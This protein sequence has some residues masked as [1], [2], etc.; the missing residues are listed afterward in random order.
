MTKT[1]NEIV[2]AKPVN[3]ITSQYSREQVDLIKSTVAVG[4]TDLELKLFLSQCERTGLDALTRQIYFSVSTNKKGER[5]VQIQ[6][7]IDGFRLI[8]E[9]SG[10]YEGQTKPEWCG[11]DGVWKD[12]WLSTNLPKAAR[13]GV[14]KTGFKEPLYAVAI[15][16]EYAQKYTDGNLMFMWKKMPSLMISKVAES[17]ALRKAFPNEMSGIYTVEELPPESH[18]EPEKKPET[19]VEKAKQVFAATEKKEPPQAEW[20]GKLA[21]LLMEYG[22]QSDDP[23]K[24]EDRQN[25]LKK[26]FGTHLANLLIKKTVEELRDGMNALYKELEARK[27]EEPP[28]D[29]PSSD[30][31]QNPYL[32]GDRQPGAEG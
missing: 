23:K 12:I 6:T 4:A 3:A 1:K 19:I 31:S 26:Y 16:D 24:I 10:K 29:L 28:A 27:P 30:D 8:A 14:Y 7:S 11:A 15:F 21:D 32:Q 22:L 5:K 2:K 17:L 9:R 13:I 18:D 20:L 25:L